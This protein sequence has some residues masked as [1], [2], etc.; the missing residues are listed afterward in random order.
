MGKNI[1]YHERER[2][3]DVRVYN[4]YMHMKIKHSTIYIVSSDRCRGGSKI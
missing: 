1:L 2:E 4:M 3:R